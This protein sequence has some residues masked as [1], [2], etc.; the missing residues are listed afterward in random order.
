MAYREKDGV[1]MRDPSRGNSTF[2]GTGDV[3]CS[4]ME[5]KR[6]ENAAGGS[7]PRGLPCAGKALRWM[8]LEGQA[9]KTRK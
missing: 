2:K 1:S 6:L 3:T 8:S 5:K 4:Q 9:Q 7:E